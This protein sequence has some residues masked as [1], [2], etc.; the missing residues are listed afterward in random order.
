MGVILTAANPAWKALFS[1]QVFGRSPPPS[2]PA[3]AAPS[4]PAST[5][6]PASVSS[7]PLQLYIA[8]AS[9]SAPAA[10]QIFMVS[11]SS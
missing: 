7:S 2:P 5:G 11:S 8:S 9:N 1:G 3:S 4:A 6:G 10:I